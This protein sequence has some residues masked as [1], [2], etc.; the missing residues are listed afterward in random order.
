MQQVL[1]LCVKTVNS[2]PQRIKTKGLQGYHKLNI[3]SVSSAEKYLSSER[4][5]Y[6][7]VCGQSLFVFS[8]V[9]WQP[10]SH[11]LFS[12]CAKLKANLL[13]YFTCQQRSEKYLTEP[14]R[15]FREVF[16][17]LF[18]YCFRKKSPVHVLKS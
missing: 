4:R 6:L 1:R 8:L 10:H 13:P 12:L 11:S 5:Y 2:L 18:S 16:F 14:F 7:L 15:D 3:F 9:A 17:I